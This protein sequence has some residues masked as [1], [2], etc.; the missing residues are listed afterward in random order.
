MF[1]RAG[2][3]ALLGVN[4][5]TWCGAVREGATLK[6]V[7]PGRLRRCTAVDGTPPAYSWSSLL[8][9]TSISASS[10]VHC[11]GQRSSSTSRVWCH[12][13]TLSPVCV[14]HSRRFSPP[15]ALRRSQVTNHERS[16]ENTACDTP[17]RGKE[18]SSVGGC[19]SV[20]YRHTA[21]A[22]GMHSRAPS[23]EYTML[24]SPHG[25]VRGSFRGRARRQCGR[26]GRVQEFHACT[27]ADGERQRRRHSRDL[28]CRSSHPTQRTRWRGA[29]KWGCGGE[30]EHSNWYVR[31]EAG[32]MMTHD[33]AWE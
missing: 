20:E 30:G 10:A 7:S 22:V 9:C 4:T 16:G 2:P 33:T 8:T 28:G 1:S 21:F 24:C 15:A 25:K 29:P 19:C 6:A 32:L 3:V 31:K 14:D 17:G 12:P 13:R 11:T 23:A 27:A 5:A 18:C 26:E